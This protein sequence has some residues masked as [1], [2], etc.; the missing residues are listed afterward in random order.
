MGPEK[1]NVRLVAVQKR[2]GT[3]VKVSDRCLILYCS[4]DIMARLYNKILSIVIIMLGIKLYYKFDLFYLSFNQ[5]REGGDIGPF[6]TL[7]PKVL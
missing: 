1:Q 5:S 4:F 2:T 7:V 6:I 3:V